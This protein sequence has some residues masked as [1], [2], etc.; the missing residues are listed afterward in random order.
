MFVTYF[1]ASDRRFRLLLDGFAAP[2]F[3]IHAS[4]VEAGDARIDH[5]ICLHVDVPDDWETYLATKLSHKTRKNVRNF[6]RKV[7]D[8]DRFRIT[9]ADKDTIDRDLDILFRMW[10]LK[11]GDQYG[12]RTATVQRT[13]RAMI[14]HCFDE[15][16]LYMPVLWD[17]DRPLGA[18]ATVIDRRHR[19]ML[20]KTFARDETFQNPSPGLILLAHT[21]RHAINEGLGTCDFLQGNHGYKY[22]FG[23]DEFAL[24]HNAVRR[25][26]AL[27]LV[28]C[29]DV[30]WLSWAFAGANQMRDAG[31][32]DDAIRAYRQI[33]ALDPHNRGVREALAKLLSD[34]GHHAAA[35]RVLETRPAAKSDRVARRQAKGRE[36]QSRSRLNRR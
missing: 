18:L 5:R 34:K 11:W 4:E 27:K 21:I 31:Q 23:V 6:L 9:Y 1:S 28:D 19:T 30:R 15:G 22:S 36:P 12:S 13:D 10:A 20:F 24:Q 3:V 7:E 14:R 17:G 26:R 32:H 8:G 16:L 35:K 33:L 2:D 29:L 25:K